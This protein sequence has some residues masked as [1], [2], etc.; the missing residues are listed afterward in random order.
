M[1]EIENTLKIRHGEVRSHLFI[2]C[3][4]IQ[5]IASCLAMTKKK[6]FEIY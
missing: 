5:E 6:I 3:S 4:L 1:I 2:V